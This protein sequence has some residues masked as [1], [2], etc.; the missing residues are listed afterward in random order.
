MQS[1]SPTTLVRRDGASSSVIVTDIS[2]DGCQLRSDMAFDVGELV[3]L[4]TSFS[5]AYQQRLASDV[6]VSSL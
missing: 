6:S 4:N 5:A 1:G 2:R 3:E